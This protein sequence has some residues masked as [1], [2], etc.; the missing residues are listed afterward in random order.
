[1]SGIMVPLYQYSVL[2]SSYYILPQ[3]FLWGWFVRRSG[4]AA[5]AS[6]LPVIASL[7]SLPS[8]ICSKRIGVTVP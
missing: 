3:G 8:S 6:R 1:M 5:F 2:C 7:G 4:P